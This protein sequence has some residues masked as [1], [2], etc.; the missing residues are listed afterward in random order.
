[1]CNLYVMNGYQWLWTVIPYMAK[2]Q[3]VNNCLSPHKTC[4][5]TITLHINQRVLQHWEN[6]E[7]LRE[8]SFFRT[9]CYIWTIYKWYICTW[10]RSTS[11]SYDTYTL[12]TIYMTLHSQNIWLYTTLLNGPW[13]TSWVKTGE[14]PL[15]IWTT[16][17]F[18]LV[19][20]MCWPE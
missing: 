2:I 5:S 17:Q 10:S 20:S 9:G 18:D 8:R 13:Y 1:M 7:K 11:L 15:C 16:T 4:V 3:N 6:L 14:I 12:S 19:S